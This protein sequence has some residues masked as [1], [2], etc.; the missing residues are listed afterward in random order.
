[1]EDS[2]DLLP[3]VLLVKHARLNTQL[4][5]ITEEPMS[6]CLKGSVL[7]SASYRKS[8]LLAKLVLEKHVLNFTDKSHVYIEMF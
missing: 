7:P 3:T 6:Y 4:T 2:E 1:M 5:L 8:S